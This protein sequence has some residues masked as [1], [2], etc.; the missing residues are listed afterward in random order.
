[1]KLLPANGLLLFIKSERAAG[2]AKVD[3]EASDEAVQ[4]IRTA[5]RRQRPT[6]SHG[7]HLLGQAE[8]TVLIFSHSGRQPP[9]TW[10]DSSGE[11]HI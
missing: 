5:T 9:K 7:G 3:T 10:R 1:M 6:G 11:P 2:T 8:H 4:Q